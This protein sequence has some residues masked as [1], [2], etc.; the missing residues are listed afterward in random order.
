MYSF[1]ESAAI[2]TAG[3]LQQSNLERPNMN[4]SFWRLDGK[5]A[6]VTGA[7][8]GIGAAVVDVLRERGADVFLTARTADDV[9]AFVQRS[10]ENGGKLYGAAFDV[11][12]QAQRS[13]LIEQCVDSLGG[14]DILVNNVGTNIRRRMDE[15]RKGE[16]DFL[17]QTNL[18]SAFELCRL[19]YPHL[20]RS[21]AASV[22]NMSS[23]AAATHVRTGAVYGMTKAALNQLTRNLAG[24]WGPDGI[25]VNALAPW[26]IR[27]PLAEQVLR[28]KSYA[29]AVIDRTPLGRV[30]EASEV[31]AAVAFLCMPGAA[32]ISGQILA[33]DGGMSIAGF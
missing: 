27:T 30:G 12:D 3:C 5:K 13:S 2:S 18:V 7:T 23:I 8:K 19:A 33:I 16:L 24:E 26:Y 31:A 14:L 17:L 32:Y 11:T 25:R 4:S 21:E 6:L 29:Q 10:P 20:R 22:V 9:Q 15:Y 1:P 28:D